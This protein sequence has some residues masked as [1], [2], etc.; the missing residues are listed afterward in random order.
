M[1]PSVLFYLAQ[2]ARLRPYSVAWI[3]RTSVLNNEPEVIHW[4]E[5]AD[6]LRGVSDSLF[7]DDIR[8]GDRVA[9][10][11]FNSLNWVLAELACTA[12]GATSVPLD[13]RL[14]SH[15]V[16]EILERV[17]P[18]ATLLGPE[19][20]G[21]VAGQP[22]P[23][24]REI[25]T[26][27]NSQWLEDLLRKE[28]DW[29]ESQPATIL[30]TSG[31]TDSPKGVMLSHRNL[32]S[33]ALAKLDAMPQFPSDHRVNLLPFA[34]AYA[35]T[36]EL[37]TWLISGSSMETARGQEDFFARLSTAKPTLL[38]AVPSVYEAF[39]DRLK[40]QSTA[41]IR[42]GL[43]GN[44]RQ[45]ASGGAPLSDRL[46][47][48]YGNAGL[49][50]Y[51]G[52]G[53]TETSPVVCSNI[54][55]D[56]GAHACLLGVGPPV[57]GVEV[58]IDSDSQ[59]WVRGSNLF[60]GYW[61]DS[62]AT[63]RRWKSLDEHESEAWFSTGDL[64][65]TI[66]GT[67]AI[68]ILGRADDTIVLSNGYKLNPLVLESQLISIPALQDCVVIPVSQGRWRVCLH[69]RSGHE[70]TTIREINESIQIRCSAE[71]RDRM[72][73]AIV[74]QEPWTI[75]SGVLNFKGAKRRSEFVKRYGH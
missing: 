57:M 60:M 66:E 3:E 22:L 31:T 39:I 65:R 58:Q 72:A 50:I 68:E 47:G 6:L 35:R 48:L 16:E 61:E 64:A 55:P 11:G 44:V 27:G 67:N 2:H 9:I 62:V 7:R 51:Q 52:Y 73:D 18:K 63:E 17:S 34:H 28:P 24:W 13:P 56:S 5:L 26:R 37:T 10:W 74:C 25:R 19:H 14:P 75:E 8:R 41:A 23:D 29:T 20:I 46:R 4:G 45:L 21:R 42:S 49:P 32:V 36:C 59:L 43:G 69:L 40:I 38:N 71:F 33:N 15:T 12:L 30:F 54:H 53:L 70:S 1:P